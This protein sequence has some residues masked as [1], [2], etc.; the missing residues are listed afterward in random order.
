[1]YD[2]LMNNQ[3]TFNTKFNE[4]LG[5]FASNILLVGKNSQSEYRLKVLKEN[6]TKKL[7]AT[8]EIEN[9]FINIFVPDMPALKPRSKKIT[10]V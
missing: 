5:C 4:V 1:M 7:D 3:Q 10:K 2:C 6:I 9:N 8:I